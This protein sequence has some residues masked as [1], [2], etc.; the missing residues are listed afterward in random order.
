M[1]CFLFLRFLFFF[2]RAPQNVPDTEKTSHNKKKCN[3][4]PYILFANS[5]WFLALFWSGHIEWVYVL[6]VLFKLS[7]VNHDLAKLLQSWFLYRV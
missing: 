3:I 5:Q 7:N 4:L 6:Y 2:N 1:S